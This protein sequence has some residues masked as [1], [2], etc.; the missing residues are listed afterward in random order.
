MKNREKIMNTNLYDLLID[1]KNR[2][3]EQYGYSFCIL[4]CFENEHL[5]EGT[6]CLDCSKCIQKWL[7][8]EVKNG[9]S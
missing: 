9:L 8:V 7:N 2:G 6:Y 3:K 1:M 5:H 4:D